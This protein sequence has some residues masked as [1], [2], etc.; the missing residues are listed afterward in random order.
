MIQ[1]ADLKNTR[2]N[3]AAV[4]SYY[5]DWHMYPMQNR[6][7]PSIQL[8]IGSCPLELIYEDETARDADLKTLDCW[9]IAELVNL[10]LNLP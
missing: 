5:A 1:M 9:S 8:T 2:L 3:P 10:N 6:S 7:A 4:T